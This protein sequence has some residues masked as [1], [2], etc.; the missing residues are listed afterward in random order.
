MKAS[1]ILEMLVWLDE[2]VGEG[3][4]SF[5]IEQMITELNKHG[6]SVLNM[7]ELAIIN[8]FITIKENE[9]TT[10]KMAR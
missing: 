9:R 1:E 3:Q 2:N 6:I 5:V 7:S 8:S 10:K 4:A